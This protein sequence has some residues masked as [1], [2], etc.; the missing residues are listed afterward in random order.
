MLNAPITGLLINGAVG[1][2]IAVAAGMV[3]TLL[4]MNIVLGKEEIR[5][6]RLRW[7]LLSWSALGAIMGIYAYRY[8][9][10]NLTSLF[11]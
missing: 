2:I 7:H 5:E 1:G 6:G 3:L 9:W 10:W 8:G 11:T 4:F